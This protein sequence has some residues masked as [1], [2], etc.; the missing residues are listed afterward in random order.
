MTLAPGAWRRSRRTARRTC[1]VLS[2]SRKERQTST[3]PVVPGAGSGGGRSSGPATRPG[4]PRDRPVPPEELGEH[5]VPALL[6]RAGAGDAQDRRLA[7]PSR[8]QV[9]APAD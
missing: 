9:R 5:E 7:A 6:E 2:A 3:T 8:V 4:P 1:A